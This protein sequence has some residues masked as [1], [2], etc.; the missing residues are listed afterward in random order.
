[1]GCEYTF[2]GIGSLA[3]VFTIGL[4]KLANDYYEYQGAKIYVKAERFNQLQL[5]LPYMPPLILIAAMIWQ[6]ETPSGAD[7]STYIAEHIA[8]NVRNTCI[9]SPYIPALESLKKRK[10]GFSDLHIHLNGAIETDTVWQDMLQHPLEVYREIQASQQKSDV[11]ELYKE[12]GLVENAYEFYRLLCIAVLIRQHLCDYLMRNKNSLS[13]DRNTKVPEKS[14]ESLLCEW[15]NAFPSDVLSVHHPLQCAFDDTMSPILLECYMYI[16][17][18]KDLTETN[19][20]A[21]AQ[22]FHYYLLIL[23]YANRMLVHQPFMYGFQEFQKYTNNGFR[24]FSER[25]F[26]RRFGQLQGNASDH[27]RLIEGRFSPKETFAKNQDYVARILKGWKL[28]EDSRKSGLQDVSMDNLNSTSAG[29]TLFKEF[30]REDGTVELSL[31][32]HFIKQR[33]RT[34]RNLAVCRHYELRKILDKKRKAL[35]EFV[36]SKSQASKYIVGV[37]CAASEFDTSPEV[38]S[39]VYRT[40]RQDGTIAHFTYHAG[41]DFFHLLG[42]LRAIYEAI[43]FLN[44][45]QGDRI[46][47]ATAAGVSPQLWGNIGQKMHIKEGDY[48][49]DLTFAYSLIQQQRMLQE[50]IP[51]LAVKMENYAHNIY[52]QVYSASLLE[53]AWLYRW[54]DPIE[55]RNEISTEQDDVQK[56]F[57]SYHSEKVRHNYEQ[58]IEVDPFDVFSAEELVL[59]QQ[60]LLREMHQRSIVIE[61]LPTSNVYIGHHHGYATYHLYNW[62]QWNKSGIPLP[63]IVV[64]TDDAGVFAT[65]IYNEYCHIYC[66]LKYEKHLNESDIIE[67]ISQLN[68]NAEYYKFSRL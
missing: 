57:L 68:D 22:L 60:M 29:T 45:C 35:S 19:N 47:H 18:F 24:E 56:V 61:T 48:L 8:P 28:S 20:D 9:L 49:D 21:V 25:E 67:F 46:G 27:V 7:M 30:V 26:T 3:Q 38:F 15:N 65:N 52:G 34:P 42:G 36:R 66:M 32:A 6:Y 2:Q 58:I 43:V 11:R 64:G 59:L 39:S 31:I 23:G 16:L 63:P 40:L 53:R 51:L 4:T 10:G 13:V 14:V 55:L 1:L 50:K 41:E 33:D 54:H 37:D 17:A 5:L 44:L 62:M 12:V